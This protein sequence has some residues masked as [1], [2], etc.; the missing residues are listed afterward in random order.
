MRHGE[1]VILTGATVAAERS[2]D[3]RLTGGSRKLLP[4]NLGWVRE[5]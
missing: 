2:E 3:K 4:K 1:E 5:V